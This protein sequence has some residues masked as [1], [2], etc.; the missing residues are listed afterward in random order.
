MVGPAAGPTRSRMTQ[1][2]VRPC[3][4]RELRRVGGERSCINVSDLLLERGL[5]AIK[6]ISARAISLAERP[7]Q[8]HLGHQCLLTQ[9]ERVPFTLKRLGLVA[10]ERDDLKPRIHRSALR[11][12]LMGRTRAQH[13]VRSRHILL[14]KRQR[15]TKRRARSSI[16]GGRHPSPVR[17]DNRSAD[18]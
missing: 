13:D 5:L 15:E 12:D 14:M 11:L 16:V 1:C 18:R 2:M 9:R 3:V 4:A 7:Q 17:F 6:N 10:C 8:G